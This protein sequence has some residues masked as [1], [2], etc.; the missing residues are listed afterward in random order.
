MN[1]HQTKHPFKMLFVL[2]TLMT[3]LFSTSTV[4]A[5]EKAAKKQDR[6]EKFAER[7]K[8]NEQQKKDLRPLLKDLKKRRVETLKAL[9]QEEKKALSK[10]LNEEQATKVQRM[11]AQPPKKR[12]RKKGHGKKPQGKQPATDKK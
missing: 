10:I 12:P 4:W 7:L 1:S 9:A 3:A 5:E 11:L 8:L 2:L 6:Y